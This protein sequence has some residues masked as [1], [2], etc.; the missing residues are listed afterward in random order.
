MGWWAHIDDF[1]KLASLPDFENSRWYIVPKREWLS[2]VSVNGSPANGTSEV[3]LM[4]QLLAVATKVAE[5]AAASKI[6]RKRRF[7]VAE[8]RWNGDFVGATKCKTGIQDGNSCLQIQGAW[9]EAS[10]GFIV[11]ETWPDS[12]TYKP[13]GYVPGWSPCMQKQA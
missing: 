9:V 7:M 11:E 12:K 6:A 3:L 8:V 5:E 4:E 13:H 2:P 1:A 10:R